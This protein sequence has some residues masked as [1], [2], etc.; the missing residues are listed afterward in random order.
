MSAVLMKIERIRLMAGGTINIGNYES[1]KVE[2]SAEGVIE[3]GEDIQN[4]KAQLR[5]FV[6]S[7]FRE[8]VKQFKPAKAAP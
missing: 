6:Q 3:P 4:A 5:D 8:A 7:S 1:L 2:F